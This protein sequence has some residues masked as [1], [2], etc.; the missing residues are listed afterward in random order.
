V[1]VNGTPLGGPEGPCALERL[2]AE[3]LIV[4]LVYGPEVT[5]W[6]LACR[7]AGLQAIDGLGLLVHQARHA[8]ALWTGRDVPVEPLARAVGWPR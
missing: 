1:V 6:V 3:A 2:P 8:L 4:D 7:A 5:P